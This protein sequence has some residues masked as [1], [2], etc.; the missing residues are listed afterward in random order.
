MIYTKNEIVM[1]ATLYG[2]LAR[3]QVA[4]DMMYKHYVDMMES[5]IVDDDYDMMEAAEDGVKKSIA[6]M[7]SAVIDRIKAYIKDKI[8]M[9]KRKLAI[10]KLSDIGIKLSKAEIDKVIK[11]TP[12]DKKVKF[13]DVDRILTLLDRAEKGANA[14]VDR[15]AKETEKMGDMKFLDMMKAKKHLKEFIEEGRKP[16]DEIFRQI[17]ELMKNEN[18]MDVPVSKYLKSVAKMQE[19]ANRLDSL[20]RMM[21]DA[22]ARLK[23]GFIAAAEQEEKLRKMND[24]ELQRYRMKDR[25]SRVN[26][27]KPVTGLE[28]TYDDLLGDFD[29][30][31]EANTEKNMTMK[32]KAVSTIKAIGSSVLSILNTWITGMAN[33]LVQLFRYAGAALGYLVAVSY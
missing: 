19:V 16:I 6:E 31:M 33:I 22:G 11:N 9:V 29:D 3:I 25:M 27:S 15:I 32:E 28:S 2:D 17:Q 8:E 4:T 13:V 12:P 1:E 10:K 14:F 5:A 21:D 7:F 30:Y 24:M 18:Q 23:N 20:D 26:G